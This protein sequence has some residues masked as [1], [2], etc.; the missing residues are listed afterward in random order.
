M[1]L[2][3]RVPRE[4]S[5]CL[6]IFPF[7]LTES[8]DL[9]DISWYGRWLDQQLK[10]QPQ[11]MLDQL[12]HASDS[13]GTFIEIARLAKTDE[14]SSIDDMVSHLLDSNTVR[15]RNSVDGSR[16]LKGF[17]FAA[18]G[19]QTMLYLPA[20]GTCPPQQLALADSLDGFVGQA[21][22][23]VKQDESGTKRSLQEFLLNFGLMLPRENICISQEKEDTQAF[24]SL[25]MINSVQ[26][27]AF[28]LQSIAHIQI[29][30]VDVLAPHLEFDRDTNTLFLFRYPSFCL[31]NLP[32]S[33]DVAGKGVI[34]R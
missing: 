33:K 3:T 23:V 2:A 21:Y 11:S 20:F 30:W 10:N 15:F 22:M 25:T 27:N 16:A 31:A 8:P 14:C 32:P 13:L 4:Q 6:S 26:F 9:M 24:E 28:L 12:E 1:R 7:E 18:L 5:R 34:H 29:K 17:V 19:W